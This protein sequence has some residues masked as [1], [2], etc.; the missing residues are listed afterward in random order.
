MAGTGTEPSLPPTGLRA[1]E[2]GTAGYTY[3]QIAA[4]LGYAST[5]TVYHA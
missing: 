1:V 4:K 2:L 5:G 3:D